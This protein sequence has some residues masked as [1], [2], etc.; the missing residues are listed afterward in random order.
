MAILSW[1][2]SWMTTS[3]SVMLSRSTSGRAP[4]ISSS[5]RFWISAVSLNRPPTLL[6]MSSLLSASI[7]DLDSSGTLVPDDFGN[8]LDCLVQLIVDDHVIERPRALGHVDFAFG[9]P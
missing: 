4:S 1:R 6:T 7:I 3:R 2:I 9:G 5:M 8:L